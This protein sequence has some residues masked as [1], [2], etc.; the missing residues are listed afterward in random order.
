M[1]RADGGVRWWR[2]PVLLA[3]AAAIVACAGEKKKPGAA[4]A[5]KKRG[6]TVV[7]GVRNDFGPLNPIVN[8]DQYTDEVIKY[9]LYTPL[10]QFDSTLQPVPYLA[11]SWD[12]TGDTGIVFHIRHDVRWH[13]GPFVTAQD[14]KF[15]FDLAKNP[16]TASLLAAAYL[17]KVDRAT[18]V[19]SFTIRFHFSAP[20]AQAI[21]DFWWPPVPAHLLA[22]IPPDQLRNAEFNRHPVGSGPYHFNMWQASDR[23]VIEHELLFPAGLGGPTALDRVVFRIIPEP[24]TL[25]TELMSGGV[26][27]DIGLQPEQV[28][29]VKASPRERLIA[30]PGRTVYF[31]AWN[32]RR[33]PFNDPRVRRAMTMAIDR[34]QITDVVLRGLGKNAVSP[35][36]PWSPVIPDVDP[37][38]YDPGQAAQL[39]A[40]AGFTKK[41]GSPFAT[42]PN[43]QPLHVTLITES[44]PLT[45][46]VAQIIQSQLRGLGVQVDVRPL[47]F[48][49]FLAQYKS[50][51]FDAA[52]G[53]W[54]MDNFQV[55]SAPTALF[56]SSLANVPNS[57]NRAGVV[58]PTLDHLLAKASAPLSDQ[59]A[60]SAWKDFV[61]ELQAE[62]PF[63]FM[64]WWAELAG[65]D[66]RVQGV[67]MDPRGQ[68]VS[69]KEWWLQ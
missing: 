46:D 14:V 60:R 34:P 63:T 22:K 40:Q 29:Q 12:M 1:V 65:V 15:T 66:R 38:P 4:A 69:M 37:L 59:D 27:V 41:P 18:V 49:T 23:L 56:S 47:E 6:G 43:G 32:N 62:Q 17:S 31:I 39:L 33:P 50:K 8:T 24:S 13:D 48:Q 42:G 26:Q 28:R 2:V 64:F 52:F 11:Q 19:D 7:V 55:A 10:I 5:A 53:N 67:V 35:I 57:S 51:D 30:F 44:R 25:V 68:L 54:V 61:E 16:V 9:G 3:L 58:S 36:P 21:Q 20:H 45:Q